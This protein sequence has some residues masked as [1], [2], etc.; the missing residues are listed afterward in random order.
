MKKILILALVMLPM[1]AFAQVTK[2]VK[3]T[4][5]GE[6]ANQ[7]AEGEKFSIV[8]LTISGPMN[9]KDMKLLQEIVRTS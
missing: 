6:L 4:H 9:G 3:L 1:M 8:S 7:I 2:N 5:A